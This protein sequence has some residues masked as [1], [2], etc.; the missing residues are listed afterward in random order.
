[1]GFH[2]FDPGRADALESPDRYRYV[3]VEELLGALRLTGTGT[4][5]DLGS[6]T[7]FYTDDIAP[8]AD[9]V[10]AVD[11]QPEMHDFYRDKGL[12]ANVEPITADVAD[13][14]FDTGEL[15]AAVSTMTLHEFVGEKAVRE[16][17]RVLSPGGRFVIADWSARGEG[18]VGPPT[19]ERLDAETA[20]E[21]IT[22]D[23]FE[24]DRADERYE[25]FFIIALR[26]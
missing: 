9:A 21:T 16:V 11:V 26:G 14:P 12:P 20:A 19:D 10:Y 8:F 7:G 15:D 5:A 3:S 23:G 1:M 18:D 4:I 6:G 13:L 25:T 2:T 22:R 24:I 17:A